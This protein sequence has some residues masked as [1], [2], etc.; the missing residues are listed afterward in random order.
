[1]KQTR[2][3]PGTILYMDYG[4]KELSNHRQTALCL[5]KAASCLM[6]KHVLLTMRMVP[7][8]QHSEASWEKQIPVFLSVLLYE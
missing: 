3:A 7:S 6:R 2:F 4:E 1:M 8:G 5:T